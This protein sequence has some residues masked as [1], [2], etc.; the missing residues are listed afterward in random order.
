MSRV[1]KY[2]TELD[3]AMEKCIE[4]VPSSEKELVECRE[5][6]FTE[7]EDKSNIKN[8]VFGKIR[9]Q[10]KGEI[11]QIWESIEKGSD[12]NAA[13]TVDY[14]VCGYTMLDENESALLA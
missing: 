1:Q 11:T 14:I 5:K 10:C 6:C 8:V 2:E 13:A 7:V 9:E 3:K 12:V 4:K